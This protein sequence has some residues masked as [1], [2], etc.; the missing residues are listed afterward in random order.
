MKVI[1]YCSRN[2]EKDSI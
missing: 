2:P 1:M